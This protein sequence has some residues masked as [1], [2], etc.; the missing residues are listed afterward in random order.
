MAKVKKEKK[1][2]MFRLLPMTVTMLCLLLVV[3]VN[4][5]YIGSKTLREMYAT[6]DAIAEDKKEVKKPEEKAAAKEGEAKPAATE[7]T[8]AEAKP[9]DVAAAAAKPEEVKKEAAPSGA[10]PEEA[11]PQEAHGAAKP[12]GEGEH[13]EKKAEGEHGSAEA[14]APVEPRTHGTGRSTV[15]AIEEMKAKELQPRY[16]QTELDLL[17]NLSKRRDELDQREK[18]LEIK[19]KVLEATDKRIADKMNEMKTLKNDLS[20]VLAQYN[21]KQGAQ[22]RSLVKIYENM[23]PD[24][25]A[26]I[27]NE[28]EMPILLEVIGK[29]SE[30]KV[31]LVLANMSP[32][33]ARDVTQE[34]A[35]KRKKVAPAADVSSA[36]KP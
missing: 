13:G 32:K 25:A 34:L 27:F 33:K 17:Q 21:E 14:K 15:K 3:K 5:L 30:R 6:R 36:P 22:I 4:E 31:A 29:M 11:K 8:A 20:G 7:K 10:A 9:A 12:E 16:S 18:D 28:M 1:R 35:E 24:E 26:A 23:K 19:A 2:R